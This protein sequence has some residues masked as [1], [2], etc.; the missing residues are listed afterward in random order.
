MTKRVFIMT[1]EEE[2]IA[3]QAFS[4]LKKLQL[5]QLVE[6]EQMAVVTNRGKDKLE[7]QDFLDFT[8][9]DKTAKGS[10]IGVLVG[11]LGGPIGILLGWIGGTTIGATRD[12]KEIKTAVSVFE[13][14]LDTICEGKTGIILIA[15][16]LGQND[17]RR[18]AEDKFGGSLLQL[19]YEIVME[20]IEDAR[21][22]E[23]ELEKEAKKRWFEKRK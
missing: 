3:Y 21:E 5:K 1:F 20:E 6:I 7:M 16:V 10:L 4:N 8:G 2:S 17:L 15:D 9:A 11:I 18:S 22:T 19:D 12:A 23:K 13:Q 14:T